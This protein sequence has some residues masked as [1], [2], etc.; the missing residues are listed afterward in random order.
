M[1][2]RT[3]LLG[4]ALVAVAQPA[5]ANSFT[6]G[7]FETNTG[8]GQ[9]GYNTTA[10]GWTTTGYNFLFAPGAADTSGADG[11]YGTLSL[12]GPHNG[13]I[14]STSLDSPTAGFIYGADGAFGVAPLEQIITGLTVGKTYSVGFD[15]ALAQQAGFSGDTIQNWTV[16][17]AGQSAATPLYTLANHDFSGWFHASY[18]FVANNATETLSFLAYGNLPVPPF[19]LLDGVTFTPD[20][21]GNVP[22]P[23]SWAMML[24]GF[25]LLGA[26]ARRRRSSV[27][28]AIT[29]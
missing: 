17:F 13:G 6:N 3:I 16:S 4:A 19:A 22:E 29:A 25:G 7:N 21:V 14:S 9:L 27:A 18:D 10:S 20:S 15:Y 1:N 11:V 2:F 28:T 24:V 5:L 8:S 23:A 26:A 12:W